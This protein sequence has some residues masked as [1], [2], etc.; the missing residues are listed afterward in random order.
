MTP[1]TIP[2]AR[3]P[4]GWAMVQGQRVPVEIDIEWMRYLAALVERS[5]GING[6]TNFIEYINQLFDAPPI[7]SGLQEA[8]RAVDE[9]RNALSSVR[10]DANAVRAAYDELAA[11]LAGVRHVADLRNRLD[12]IESLI[13]ASRPA[14]IFPSLPPFTVPTLVN[15]WADIG[16]GNAPTG[17][18]KDPFGIVHLRGVLAGG[19]TNSTAF[20]LPVGYRPANVER[21]ASVSN[22]VY[23][24][25][26]IDSTGTVQPQISAV[27]ANISLCGITFRTD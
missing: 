24:W 10:S 22:S 19:V 4:L 9:L 20:T 23:G 26:Y 7:D 21:F 2:Q 6:D 1:L 14:P 15:S 11:A 27:G 18:Y 13:E 3:I 8:L 25:V 17:Y 5:G 16:I 12:D